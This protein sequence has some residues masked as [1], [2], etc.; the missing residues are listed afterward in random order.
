MVFR[1][2]ARS[3]VLLSA[4]LAWIALGATS[5]LRADA[6]LSQRD[7][8]SLRQ[9]ILSI[10]Q[11]AVSTPAGARLTPVDEAE[12][13]SYIRFELADELPAGIVDPYVDIVGGGEVR[14]RAIVD[15]DL[16]RQARPRG[17]LD[18]MAYLGG[19]VPVTASGRVVARQGE[20][21]FEFGSATVAGLGVPKLVLDELVAFYTRSQANP[22]GLSLDA[23]FALPV[24]IAEIAVEP[25]RAVVLQR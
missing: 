22:R 14:A 19:R 10:R 16:V 3:L 18:P 21:R 6:P 25:G 15:L 8:D 13:N 5:G 17:W 23:P 4:T 1:F 24:R 12:L 2:R 20:A 7:A 9:K 11:Y